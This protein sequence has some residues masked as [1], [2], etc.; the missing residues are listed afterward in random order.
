VA[1]N[2]V[3]AAPTAS[4]TTEAIGLAPRMPVTI[5]DTAAPA[6]CCTALLVPRVV[7]STET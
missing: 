5:A 7:I 3:T 4:P 1:N 2:P 6:Y